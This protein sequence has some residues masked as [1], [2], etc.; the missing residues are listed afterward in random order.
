MKKIVILHIITSLSSGGTERS[1]YNLIVNSPNYNHIVIS[2]ISNGDYIKKL[3]NNDI[4]VKTLNLKKNFYDI[5]KVIKLIK[6][7]LKYKPKLIHCWTY[8][9]NLIGGIFSK[10]LFFNN[11]IWSIRTSNADDIDI[12]FSTKMI[13]RLLSYFSYFIPKLIISNSISGISSHHKKGFRNIFKYIPNGCDQKEFYKDIKNRENIRN[14]YHI[15]NDQIVIGMCSR[16][17]IQKNHECLF[18]SI[19]ILKNEYPISFKVMLIGEGISPDNNFLQE[20]ILKYK[21][22]DEI[23]ILKHT[24]E[25]RNIYN[26][27]DLNILTSNVE[28]FP[29][30]LIESLFCGTHCIATNVGDVSEILNEVGDIVNIDDHIEL[31]KKIYKNFKD[32]KNRELWEKKSKLNQNLIIKK[33]SINNMLSDYDKIWNFKKISKNKI[34]HIINSLNQGGAEKALTNLI[35]F[36]DKNNHI[37]VSLL[38]KGFFSKQLENKKIKIYYLNMSKKNILINFFHIFRLILITLRENPKIIQTW[39]Y[40]SDFIGSILSIILFKRNVFWTI[41]N[42]NLERK[43]NKFFTNIILKIN[44][45]LSFYIPKKIICCSE[46]SIRNHINFGFSEKKFVFIPLGFD[47][48]LYKPIKNIDIKKTIDSNFLIKKTDFII[49][50]VARWHEQKN[51][52]FLLNSFKTINKS[53]KNIKLILVGTEMDISNKKLMNL[54]RINNVLDYTLLLGPRDNIHELMNIFDLNVLVSYSEA[55]P[56]VLGEAMS[57]GTPCLSS[58]VGDAKDILGDYGKII[59]IDSNENFITAIDY[60]IKMKENNNEWNKLKDNCRSHIIKN[61]GIEGIVMKYHKV[62]QLYT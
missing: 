62:W 50:C 56:N 61:Y 11:I 6:L 12:K 36:D 45:F 18:K 15:K 35:N 51:H 20:M 57:S 4:T 58:N 16:W 14:K 13:I 30:V 54:I 17:D 5:F 48:N 52:S 37:V 29:N 43:Y 26:A 19:N 47:I 22:Q 60:F 33:Y 53:S 27:I 55:F 7:L 59:D 49:G 44:R 38:K 34:L 2:L 3:R 1:L 10:L 8:H 9:A 25:I 23:I 41:V 28:G 46:A 21:L 39:L 40:H 42:F 24:T 32:W 31:S